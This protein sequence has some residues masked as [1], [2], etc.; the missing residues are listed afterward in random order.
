VPFFAIDDRYGVSGAQRADLLL[1]ALA[2]AWRERTSVS[3]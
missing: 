3:P 2:V 1:E